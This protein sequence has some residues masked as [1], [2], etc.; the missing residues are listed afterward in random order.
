V[1]RLPVLDAYER[2]DICG[3]CGGRCCQSF[4]GSALP[5]DFGSTDDEIRTELRARLLTGNWAIDWW[6]GNPENDEDYAPHYFVR[7]ATVNGSGVFDPSWG[8]ACVFHGAS[9]C[10]IFDQ[11]PSGCRGLEP[12]PNHRAEHCTVHYAS[13][14]DAAIA[15]T[16][17][18]ELVVEVANS[19]KAEAAE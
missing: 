14:Q 12:N 6:E 1:T 15:W 2:P 11:R 13:K 18:H 16:P 7:P 8:G 5:G 4:P 9:G 3:P 17:Y 19:V 10:Q